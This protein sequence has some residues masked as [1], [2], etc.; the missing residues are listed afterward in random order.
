MIPCRW[1]HASTVLCK[2][3]EHHPRHKLEQSWPPESLVPSSRTHVPIETA[4][5]HSYACHEKLDGPAWAPTGRHMASS[6]AP[7]MSPHGL[8]QSQLKPKST[9]C[10]TSAAQAPVWQVYGTRCFT[11]CRDLTLTEQ[12]LQSTAP[13]SDPVCPSRTG[14][15]T[16]CCVGGL[17]HL[18][19]HCGPIS[20]PHVHG[21]LS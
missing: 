14:I 6:I 11:I 2:A 20:S 18:L 5:L 7:R 16:T 1:Q 21:A 13:R 15:P 19:C 8:T 17:A 10:A 3:V 9:H 12:R 4:K